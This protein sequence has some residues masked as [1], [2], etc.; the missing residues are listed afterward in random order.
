VAGGHGAGR[1]ER[2]RLQI[3]HRLDEVQHGV[4]QLGEVRVIGD[5][6]PPRSQ[7]PR[8]LRSDRLGAFFRRRRLADRVEG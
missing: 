5:Q 8:V 6:R 2:G 3:V 1:V 7:V 4:E